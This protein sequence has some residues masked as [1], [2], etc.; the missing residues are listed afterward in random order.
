MASTAILDFAFV[1]DLEGRL[2]LTG[3]R[4]PASI[5]SKG[6]ILG[7]PVTSKRAKQIRARARRKMKIGSDELKQLYGRPIEEW[8]HE[9]LARGRP[10]AKDG[11]F[12]G[13]SPAFIDRVLHEQI[14]KR[15][16]EVV[17]EEMNG[18]TI[19]ALKIIGLILNDETVDEKDRPIV[20]AG[21]KLDAAKFLVEH[22]IGKPKTRMESDI[23]IKLQGILGHAMVNPGSDGGF[24]LTQGYIEAQSSEEDDGD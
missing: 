14:V 15:F 11:T 13:K 6:G 22:V 4:E 8:D 2:P 7:R 16:E 1:D 18:H 3:S 21:T 20:A 19:D 9:E 23:S 10:R 24:E 5:G 17:R 12:K